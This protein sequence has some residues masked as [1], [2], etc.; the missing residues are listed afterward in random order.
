MVIYFSGTGNSEYCAEFIG[1]K[2]GYE[3]VNSFDY[4]KNQIRGEFTAEEP[5]V[6]VAPTYCWQLPHIFE[7]FIK[8]SSFEGNRDAYFV[9]TCGSDIGN[10]GASIKKLCEEKG[11]CYKG[12][13]EIVMPENYIAM[14]RVPDKEE[15]K[16]I[17]SAA[18]RPLKKTVKQIKEGQC[19]ENTKVNFIDKIKTGPVNPIFYKLFV[20][21]KAFFATDECVSCGKCVQLCPTNNIKLVEGRPVWEDKCT[22][23]MSCICKCPAEAIEYGKISLGK[24]RY[25]CVEY[26]DNVEV[27]KNTDTDNTDADNIE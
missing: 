12:V 25:Q 4:V 22:H 10:A 15:A 9:M 23:C 20:K 18:S 7:D 16:E 26:A 3:V 11:F 21:A 13:A 19:I 1:A 5:W 6:F 14:F 2:L 24:P 8:N 27:A 17:V